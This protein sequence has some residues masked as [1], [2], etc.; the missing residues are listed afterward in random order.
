MG[1]AIDFWQ[2]LRLFS[3]PSYVLVALSHV[4]QIEISTV[5]IG[6]SVV[7]SI[8][9]KRRPPI[10]ETM[11]THGERSYFRKHDTEQQ[12]RNFHDRLVLSL[13]KGKTIDK[14]LVVV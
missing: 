8:I 9:G 11:I 14:A 1:R 7:P 2:G 5:W 10:F 4:L 13:R 3:N 12:A 6:Y